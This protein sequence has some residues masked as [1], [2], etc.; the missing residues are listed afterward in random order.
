MLSVTVAQLTAAAPNGDKT[1]IAAIANESGRVFAK[2]ELNTYNRVMGFLSTALE[3]S[4]F[5]TLTENLYYTASRAAQVWP[6]RFPS[7]AAAAPYAGNPQALANKV[8]GGRM[9]NTGPN[10]GWLY[11]GQGLIQITGKDNFALLEKL[12]GLPL[13]AHP[14]LATS[15]DHLLECSVALFVHYP[16]ILEHCDQ[17]DY[18]AVWSL[19]GTGRPTG[20]VINPENHRQALT[21]LKIAIPKLDDIAVE[22]PQRLNAPPPRLP[23][24]PSPP[25]PT[26]PTDTS[27]SRAGWLML[28]GFLVV[29]VIVVAALWVYFK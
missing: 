3:E 6:S 29:A 10:D 21:K 22:S 19:V 16:N 8:Y 17:A 23:D 2:Y 12:T 27:P 20:P 4:G 14:E 7:A 26:P 11:R 28:G 1:I 9:G 18:Y 15:P 13:L 25:S 5:H 24:I